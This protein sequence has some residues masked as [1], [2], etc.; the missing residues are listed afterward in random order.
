MAPARY[1][2]TA[3]RLRSVVVVH[4]A[5]FSRNRDQQKRDA[6]RP[7]R[8]VVPGH[9]LRWHRICGHRGNAQYA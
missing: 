2:Q 9:G 1:R 7:S 3:R 8:Y 6:D 5:L 4:A